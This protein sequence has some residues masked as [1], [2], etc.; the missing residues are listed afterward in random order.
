MWHTGGND[1]DVALYQGAR[2][3]SNDL[4]RARLSRSHYPRLYRTSSGDK[5]RGAFENVK[6][7]SVA[8]MNLDFTGHFTAAGLNFEIVGRKQG[9]ALSESC[10]DLFMIDL[11]NTRL[12]RI[13]R[14][15]KKNQSD[16]HDQQTKQRFHG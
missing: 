3:A 13:C 10:L 15:S 6:N 5:S 1:N 7:I 4:P 16:K 9:F 14:A 8:F 11:D 12:R 2:L